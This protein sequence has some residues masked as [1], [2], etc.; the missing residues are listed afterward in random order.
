MM[1]GM[2]SARRALN[3]LTIAIA[4]GMAVP[5]AAAADGDI[6]KG[7]PGFVP[8]GWSQYGF[9]VGQ[10]WEYFN[11]HVRQ[12][13]FTFEFKEFPRFWM[14]FR[15]GLLGSPRATIKGFFPMSF[16]WEMRDGR[17]FIADFV[18]IQRSSN[19]SAQRINVPVQF[20][21]EQPRENHSKFFPNWQLRCG[22]TWSS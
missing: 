17:K 2:S 6:P 8:G 11:T 3:V 4:L 1:R 13:Q 19:E 5:V 20:M 12:A 16:R 21:R 15:E 10:D 7:Q 9:F 22:M 14:D 18:D